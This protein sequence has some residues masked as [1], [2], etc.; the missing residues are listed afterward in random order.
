MDH[1]VPLHGLL[2]GGG[3][4]GHGNQQGTGAVG[5]GQALQSCLHHG[6][7]TGGVE[8]G[9]VHIQVPQ[10]G[11]GLLD[12]VGNVV[13]L[14]IQKNLM[15]PGLDLPDDFRAFGIVQLHADLHKGLSAGELVQKCEGLLC[16]GKIAGYND[17]F[18]HI[19]VRLL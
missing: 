8:V 4:L 11:H 13:E 9:N 3:Q 16:A 19:T 10:N 15:P 7:G 6:G 18:P 17:V 12:G 1:Q 14:Q 2:I 5:P